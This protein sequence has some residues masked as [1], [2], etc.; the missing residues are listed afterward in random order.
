[1][2]ADEVSALREDIAILRAIVEERAKT[3]AGNSS[4][5]RGLLAAVIVQLFFTVFFA[6]V[7]TAVLDQLQKDVQEL[8]GK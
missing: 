3:A 8:K 6:G 1:M 5:L 7:K 4:L 2:S